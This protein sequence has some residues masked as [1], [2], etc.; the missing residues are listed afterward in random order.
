MPLHARRR[1][2]VD[3]GARIVAHSP[4]KESISSEEPTRSPA[5][6]SRQA[7]ELAWEDRLAEREND[8]GNSAASDSSQR[9][10]LGHAAPPGSLDEEVQ[11]C[12]SRFGKD[13]LKRN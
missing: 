12:A 6:L 13:R 5:F 9:N 10:L 1:R 2:F 8:R 7:H 3:A 11:L 4:N